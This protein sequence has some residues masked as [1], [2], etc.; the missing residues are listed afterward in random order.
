MAINSFKIVF[1]IDQ[2]LKNDDK[3]CIYSIDGFINI[4]RACVLKILT[5]FGS[6]RDASSSACK[7]NRARENRVEWDVTYFRSNFRQFRD[8]PRFR[9][10]TLKHV[11][12]FETEL[13]TRFHVL[14]T[15]I[16]DCGLQNESVHGLEE[17]ENDVLNALKH[18][19]RALVY[20][21]SW[22]RPD[23]LSPVKLSRSKSAQPDRRKFRKKCTIESANEKQNFVFVIAK[24]PQGAEELYIS[25]PNSSA[26]LRSFLPNDFRQQFAYDLGIRLFWININTEEQLVSNSNRYTEQK[27][28]TCHYLIFEA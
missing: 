16:E 3:N 23:I 25:A 2:F 10:F 12:A 28:F 13:E 15:A 6:C 9:E 20:D 21:Y 8:K 18:A 1:L 5:Y 24:C 22:D 17:I 7:I 11:E 14:K 26:V 19:L 4:I 27:L